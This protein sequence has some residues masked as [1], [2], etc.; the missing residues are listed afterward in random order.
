MDRNTAKSDSVN[1]YHVDHA[2]RIFHSIRPSSKDLW[3]PAKPRVYKYRRSYY[4][5]G[6]VCK[7]FNFTRVRVAWRGT[8]SEKLRSVMDPMN[9]SRLVKACGV[10]SLFHRFTTGAVFSVSNKFATTTTATRC[11]VVYICFDFSLAH[12]CERDKQLI[13]PALVA[14]AR[15]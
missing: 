5:T 4:V 14:F 7:N 9:C 12:V 2:W 13:V 3:I 11:G 10:R 8:Q 6:R 1:V 15:K